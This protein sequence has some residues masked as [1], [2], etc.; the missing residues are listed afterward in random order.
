MTTYITASPAYGRGFTGGG[1]YLNKA[2]VKPGDV[3]TI[4]YAKLAKVVVVKA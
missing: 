4:R 3:V 2:D 1:M